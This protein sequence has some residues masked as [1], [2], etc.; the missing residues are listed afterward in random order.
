M[1]PNYDTATTEL[2]K[3]IVVVVFVDLVGVCMISSA[4]VCGGEQAVKRGNII[5]GHNTSELYYMRWLPHCGQ[6]AS[7]SSVTGIN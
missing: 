6:Q 2:L 4:R 5:T 1:S 3:V 7:A